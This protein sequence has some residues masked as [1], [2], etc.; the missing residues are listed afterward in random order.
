MGSVGDDTGGQ[1]EDS[2]RWHE[3]RRERRAI[4]E[5]AWGNKGEREAN[6]EGEGCC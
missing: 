4:K 3:V 2:D 5:K 1:C 6:K